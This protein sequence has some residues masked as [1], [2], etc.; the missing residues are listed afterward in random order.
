MKKLL[1]YRWPGNVIELQ[2]VI[3]KAA[4]LS[5]D[6]ILA[7]PDIISDSAPVHA[8]NQGPTSLLPLAEVER[9]HII[10]VLEHTRYRI[11]GEKGA[12]TILGLKPSTL[13]FRIKKL[14][15]KK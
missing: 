1:E 9:R 2:H 10:G 11:R 8:N 15:I 14:G 13:D 5:E 12:A 7:L 3:E 4:I 6:E